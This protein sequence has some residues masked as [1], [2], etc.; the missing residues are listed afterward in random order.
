MNFGRDTRRRVV[1]WV[2]SGLCLL[3]VLLAL[4]PLLSILYT[5]VVNGGHVLSLS[6]LVAPESSGICSLASCTVGGIGPALYATL[7]VVG[8]AGLLSVPAGVLAGIYLAEYGKNPLG[9]AISFFTDVMTGSPSIVVGLFVY[10]VV[11][12]FD[13]PIVYSALSGAVALAVIM[14]PVVTRATEEGLRLVPNALREGAYALGIPRYR[15]VIQIV[16]STGRGIVLTGAILAVMRASGEVAPLLI[17]AGF[18]TRGFTG[19]G[20]EA[21]LLGPLIYQDATSASPLLV[22][23][24]WGGSLVLILLLLG[25]GLVARYA[26]RNRFK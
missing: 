8:L 4:V 25:I 19:L 18:S 12:Y 20:D 1:N 5:A 9:R 11:F 10:A 26:L 22:S 17:A 21:G 23:A 24:A 3:C 13:R 6:F 16:L 2:V 15:A 14:V 7:V